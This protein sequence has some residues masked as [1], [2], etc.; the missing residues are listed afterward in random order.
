MEKPLAP[1]GAKLLLSTADLLAN[2]YQVTLPGAAP[3]A[4]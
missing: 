3:H 2:C 4:E 1:T